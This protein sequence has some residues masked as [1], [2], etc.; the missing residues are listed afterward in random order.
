MI[1]QCCAAS[2]S[3]TKPRRGQVP[4]QDTKGK[5]PANL[6]ERNVAIVG[7]SAAGFYAASL[8][9]R[10]GRRVQVFEQSG[11]LAPAART[12][13]VTSRMRDFLGPA[14]ESSVANEIH[15][16]ELFT[17]GRAATVA[18]DRPD[19]IIE[20]S[21]LIRSL[22]FEAEQAGA[23]IRLGRRFVALEGNGHGVRLTLDSA[24]PAQQEEI[25]AETVIGAD[26]AQSRVALAAGW[27]RQQTVPLIQAVVKMPVDMPKDSVRVWFV[28]DDTPYFYWL[29]PESP[30]RA[31]LGLIGEEGAQTRRCLERFLEKRH[32]EPISFQGARIPLYSGWVPVQRNVGSGRVFLV[33]DAASQVKVSTVGGIVTGFR[34]A[35]GA[36]QAILDGGHSRELRALRRELDLHLLIRRT[37]HSFQ[38]SD[39]SR[40]VDLMNGATR[41][42]LSQYSRDEA[43]RVLWHIA[44]SQPRLLLLGLR[45][46]L[47][48]GSFLRPRD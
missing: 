5:C 35:F 22:A 17:D 28:P 24:H 27:P 19:L 34:G 10:A 32:L 7:G 23:E 16:F 48:G 3:E 39:Y 26:G 43:G 29:I 31:A 1:S 42:S 47:S 15:R 33:G 30:E 44:L 9:A 4:L 46:L 41:R 8:L 11:Q 45:G 21:R 6:G 40:L 25:E 37:I 12:L 36:C 38:Q 20:R 14:A 13:I 18:L 2:G